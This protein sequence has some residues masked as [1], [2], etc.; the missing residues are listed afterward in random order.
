[1]AA[2]S[3]KPKFATQKMPRSFFPAVNGNGAEIPATLYQKYE[4]LKT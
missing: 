2:S 1:L 3:P 4:R